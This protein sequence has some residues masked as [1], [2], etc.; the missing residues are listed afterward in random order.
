MQSTIR[1]QVFIAGSLQERFAE[2]KDYMSLCNCSA[3]NVTPNC[4]GKVSP[5]KLPAADLDR[6]LQGVFAVLK[7]SPNG[8]PSIFY[9]AHLLPVIL[10]I[11]RIVGKYRD[12]ARLARLSRA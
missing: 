5:P 9:L 1:P 7:A 2:G 12:R 3:I 11:G 8:R 10:F 6:Y 4:S